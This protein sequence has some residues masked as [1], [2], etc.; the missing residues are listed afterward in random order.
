MKDLNKLLRPWES[1]DIGYYTSEQ[2]IYRYMLQTVNGI[3]IADIW[4]MTYHDGPGI[5]DIRYQVSFEVDLGLKCQDAIYVESIE[6]GKELVEFLA[7]K[8][9]YT[10]ASKELLTL[11]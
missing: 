11:I 1:V 8:K 9:G 4:H 3:S 6:L 7:S 2:V 5:T 10:F